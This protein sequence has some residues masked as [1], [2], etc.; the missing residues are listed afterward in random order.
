[1]VARRDNVAAMISITGIHA[2]D[3]KQFEKKLE[4]ELAKLSPHR[5]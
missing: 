2:E 5:P 1:M 3:P 4:P